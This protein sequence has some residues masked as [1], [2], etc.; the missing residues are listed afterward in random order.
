MQL[1][2]AQNQ[3]TL[4]GS[5]RTKS[6][7]NEMN[8]D[9]RSAEATRLG[10]WLARRARGRMKSDKA[11]RREIGIWRVYR[12]FRRWQRIHQARRRWW[13]T[14]LASASSI[15]DEV[16]KQIDG[17]KGPVNWF[18]D[19]FGM[20]ANGPQQLTE[21]ISFRRAGRRAF[22]TWGSDRASRGSGCE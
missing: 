8:Q 16:T 20:F 5:D 2:V 6:R 7:C 17:N 19:G 11:S 22:K 12:L 3:P 21:L 9:N 1:E 13:W 14:K 15:L 18:N 4:D 10:W